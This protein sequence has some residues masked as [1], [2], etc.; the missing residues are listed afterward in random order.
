M[1]TTL[2]RSQTHGSMAQFLPNKLS[3]KK[4]IWARATRTNTCR[5]FLNRLIVITGASDGI[6]KEFAF[7]LASKKMNVV[8]V[9]RT[10]S[11]LKAIAQELGKAFDSYCVFCLGRTLFSLFSLTNTTMISFFSPLLSN[12]E[13]KYS[14]QT[15]VYAMDFTKGADKDYQALQ[16]LLEPVEVTVLGKTPERALTGLHE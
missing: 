8:L 3:C 6:G 5:I 12:T 14:I 9:S 4:K 15:K 16:Q 7:Q 1:N 13:E 10:E 2:G 11:K